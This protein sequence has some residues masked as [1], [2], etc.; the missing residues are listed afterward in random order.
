M[1]DLNMSI[2]L[3]TELASK[4]L[5][6]F[7]K[8][9]LSKEDY[10]N[11]LDAATGDGEHGSNMA[12][13]MRAISELLNTPQPP[14]LG[15]FFENIAMTLVNSVGGASGALY[16]TLFLRLSD[17]TANCEIAD[18]EVLSRSFQSA[19]NGIMELGRVK[20]GDKTLLDALNPAVISLVD[21]VKTHQ[22]L[23]T[24]LEAASIASDLGRAATAVMEARKGRGSYQG[25][26]S[27]GHI[28]PGAT[29]MSLLFSTLY[30]T[31]KIYADKN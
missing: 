8:E 15:T 23:I 31:A 19:V 5:L 14:D 9:I 6:S 24:G 2:T 7:S 20:P 28:D 17:V 26:R 30:Q 29:S 18:L 25:E 11:E 16:G 4:W 3:N 27:I 12:T 13:G 22:D 1:G 10:L 21:S